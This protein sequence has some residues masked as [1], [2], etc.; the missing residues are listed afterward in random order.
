[1]S[2]SLDIEFK[3]Y[4]TEEYAIN[5]LK[6]DIEFFGSIK[7]EDITIKEFGENWDNINILGEVWKFYEANKNLLSPLGNFYLHRDD[8]EV[9]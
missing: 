4:S 2:D 5:I 1:M 9:S 6:E 8:N 7:S 3:L